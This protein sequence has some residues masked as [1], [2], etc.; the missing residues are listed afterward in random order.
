MKETGEEKWLGQQ[1]SSEGLA[2][3]VAATVANKEPKIKAACMEIATIVNDWRAQAAGGM[4]T[5]LTL[6]E[7]C[8]IPSLL[9]GAGT[10]TQIS[11]ATE[12]KL[13]NLQHWFLRLVLQVGPGVP[14]AALCW[15]TGVMEMGLR[16]KQEKLLFVLHLRQLGEETLAGQ[17]YKEQVA[18]GWAGLAKEAKEICEELSIEDVNK[19]KLSKKEYSQ[20]VNLSCQAKNQQ[21]L[22][23]QAEN[24]KKC[25]KVFK[26]V[27]GFKSYMSDENI[28]EVR[29]YFKTRTGMLP[30][31][32]NYP[33]DRR[34]ARTQWLC[35]CGQREEEEHIIE[36]RCP[37]YSDLRGEFGDLARDEELVSFL[38]QVLRRREQLEE[39]ARE[40]GEQEE[41][42]RAEVA[43]YEA[44]SVLAS[45]RAGQFSNDCCIGL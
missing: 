10:W 41:Q 6:W 17:V 37:L 3:S 19:T 28:N 25:S 8:C 38:S 45:S 42:K 14:L 5:A 2:K 13:N 35:G 29:K 20:L 40:E 7:R 27:C 30:F 44:T 11:K 26:E 34:F 32:A 1:L 43:A 22:R 18:R 15:E 9:H 4:E 23:K 12:K 16:V 36:G 39:V 24:K 33:G 31:A 21:I